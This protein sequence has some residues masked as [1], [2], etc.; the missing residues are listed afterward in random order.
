[1]ANS[2]R[3]AAA[4]PVRTLLLGLA[5][6]AL[7]G[8][9]D[10]GRAR[11]GAGVERA[12]APAH[13]AAAISGS[14]MVVSGSPYA[15][16][17]GVR[18]LEAGGN[19]VDA[20]VAAAFALAVA[21]PTQSGLGGRTQILVRMA[22]GRVRG[23]DGTTQVPAGYD[24][25]AAPEGEHGHGAVGIPGTVAALARALEL[26]GT[27]PLASVLAPAIEFARD[28]IALPEGEARRLAAVAGELDPDSEVARVFLKDGSVPHEPGETLVQPDL[29]S[30]L[31]ALAAEGPDVFYR[32]AVARAMAADMAA[33]GGFVTAADL[34]DYR[35]VD[36]PVGEGRFAG[37]RVFGSYLPASGVTVIGILQTLER[38]APDA[39]DEGAWAAAVAEA[40]LAGF[41]DRETAEDGRTPGDAVAWLTS[42]SLADRRAREIADKLR[43]V[44]AGGEAPAASV[45]PAA[46]DDGSEPA[47]TTHVSVADADGN[48]VA[49][50]QS[51]GPTLGARVVTPGLGFLYASTLGGYLTGGGPG[52][53]PWSSQAPLIVARDGVEGVPESLLVIGGAGSRRILSALVS[54][55]ARYLRHGEPLEAAL[56]APRLHPAGGRVDVEEGWAAADALQAAGYEVALREP[57]YFARLNAVE[58][59]T[60]IGFRGVGEPRWSES[61]AGGPR[62]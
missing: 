28:G 47:F 14:G 17:A 52:Y 29:A 13:S 6:W 43:R 30:V 3:R 40:L 33:H 41:E 38:L 7:A 57:S 18:M 15:T 26:A 59:L 37:A 21:E 42:D 11:S 46:F 24:P 48:A 1:M 62:R 16:E 20:A 54:T 56:A 35:A 53:R 5:V 9:G 25:A 55:M 8:C 60:P 32:G 23:I 10:G 31:E 34:A 39:A 12:G 50:S 61:A 58:Y 49:L 19:A 2:M 45:P 4:A 22:D 27:L 44:G 51:L 36:A